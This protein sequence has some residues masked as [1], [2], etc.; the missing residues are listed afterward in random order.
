MTQWEYEARNITD[1]AK[2]YAHQEIV[3][4][5]ESIKDYIDDDPVG[6]KNIIG[7]LKEEKAHWEDI[8]KLLNGQDKDKLYMDWRGFEYE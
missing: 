4:I 2:W 5:E 1:N 7:D 8:E 3:H 6:N